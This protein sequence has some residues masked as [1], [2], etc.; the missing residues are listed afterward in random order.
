MTDHSYQLIE[1][2]AQLAPL[3]RLLQSPEPLLLAL[4]TEFIRTRTYFAKLGLLQVFDGET[5]FLVDPTTL[6]LTDMW[7]LLRRHH[8]I[9]HAF[10]EDLE[11]INRLAGGF[12]LSVFDTQVGAAFL[13]HG[14]SM[15][16][17]RFVEHFLS[18]Q[19]DKGEAR[20]DWLARPLTQAQ[21]NYAA[22]DVI[23]LLPAYQALK[24]QL[25]E[26]GW[27][28]AA[29]EESQRMADAKLLKN[30]PE[31]AYLDVKNIWRLSSQQLAVL[32]PMAT[33]RVLEAE[34]RDLALNNVV[35]G[36]SLWELARKQPKSFT[37]LQAMG[38]PPM[39]VKIHG[40]R[41]IKL[42]KQGL[43]TEASDYPEKVKRMVDYPNYKP[44]MKAFREMIAGIAAE[45]G[46]PE[47]M[48][49]T[50]KL[51]HEYLRWHWEGRVENQPQ[52]LCGWRKTL[53]E[54]PLAQLDV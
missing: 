19:V 11:I 2:E 51:M 30:D 24:A 18:V 44:A 8:W 28:S 33:W 21:L 17:Q 5:C 36:D 15:G 29:I 50:K 23:Y 12:G 22:Q 39:E 47:D 32:K 4:D 34:R 37:Q 10:N 40:N 43:Q 54:G 26:A 38:L 25:Q 53:M 46:I 42:I 13:E 7:Q 9:L 14:A 48:L 20:T 1:T 35:K 41:L 45:K 6:D 52:V 49:A 3:L 27:W 31:L 16:F